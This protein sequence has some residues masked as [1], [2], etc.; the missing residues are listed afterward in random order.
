MQKRI[1]SH[2]LFT[3]SEWVQKVRVV[4]SWRKWGLGVTVVVCQVSVGLLIW[5]CWRL[6]VVL[7]VAGFKEPDFE[8]HKSTER[9]KRDRNSR[10]GR[11]GPNAHTSMHDPTLG[12][13]ENSQFS[14]NLAC[15]LKQGT[16]HKRR[17]KLPEQCPSHIRLHLD[18]N[19]W[20]QVSL[21]PGCHWDF[22]VYKKFPLLLS[23]VVM[24]LYIRERWLSS[25]KADDSLLDT[26]YFASA[27]AQKDWILWFKLEL[28]CFFQVTLSY[29]FAGIQRFSMHRW[30]VDIWQ[31]LGRG[32][33][34]SHI[35]K[36]LGAQAKAKDHRASSFS[37]TSFIFICSWKVHGYIVRFLQ[38]GSIYRFYLQ[39]KVR[40]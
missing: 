35:S 30:S 24:Q 31:S 6:S 3:Q 21:S 14:G 1:Y 38:R 28:V 33:P 37:S 22:T 4:Q 7:G 20:K 23:V 19:I 36:M 2:S 13:L 16:Q 8:R 39:N 25:A 12:R 27:R 10:R 9:G 18:V 5:A 26:L 29:V 32:R 34:G 15:W 40:R 11:E 17:P